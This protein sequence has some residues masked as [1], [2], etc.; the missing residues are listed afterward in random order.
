MIK[1][2]GMD[3]IAEGVETI[4]QASFLENKGCSEMQG[5]FFYKPMTRNEF[6]VLF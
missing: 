6:E 5:Y 4:K 3:L 1:A 2:L